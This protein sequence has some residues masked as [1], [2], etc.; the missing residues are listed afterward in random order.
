MPDSNT[1]SNFMN[2]VMGG[3]GQAVGTSASGL[4]G[5]LTGML[6]EKHNDKRQLNQQQALQNMQIQGQEQLTDYNTAKQ[7]Q[8]WKDTSYPA[9]M[10]QLQK[11]G[12][13]PGLMYGMGG[14][15]GQ[16]A[17]IAPGSVSGAEAPKGGGE[18]M[19]M[20][21][22]SMNL[23]LLKAQKENIEA[24]TQNKESQIPGNLKEPALKESQTN[25]NIQEVENKK[26]QQALTETETSIKNID[27]HVAGMTQN[28]MVAQ[29]QTALLNLTK[30]TEILQNDKTISD[31]TVSTKVGLLKWELANSILKSYMTKAETANISQDTKNKI[32]QVQNMVQENMRGW[33]KL[34]LETQQ[35]TME[36]AKQNYEQA[37]PA[38]IKEL[39]DRILI[40][41]T[42]MKHK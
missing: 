21:L 11:A 41:P 12:L 15:G 23:Q 4:L 2:S 42:L 14:G 29:A 10:Q 19:G 35:Q 13:N 31:Q 26:A 36:Q 1:Q 40:F 28:T 24:D 17:S 39:L 3:V 34:S 16:T 22:T 6:F 9:Q 25:I 8:M 30:A 5:G 20:A 18:A 32:Q 27:L 37:V 38:E 7:L 33:D